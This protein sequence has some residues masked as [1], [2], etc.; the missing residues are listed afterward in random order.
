MVEVFSGRGTSGKISSSVDPVVVGDTVVDGTVVVGTVVDVVSIATRSTEAHDDLRLTA[1]NMAYPVTIT[2]SAAKEPSTH[3]KTLLKSSIGHH[4][5]VRS[6]RCW[7]RVTPA[8][9][10]YFSRGSLEVFGQEDHLDRRIRG[11]R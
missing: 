3:F 10:Q 11:P 9:S 7:S 2:A 1:W 4:L 8:F 5:L 6:Q